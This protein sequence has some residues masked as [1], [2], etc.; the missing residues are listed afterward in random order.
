MKVIDVMP[1]DIDID[2]YDDYDERLGIAFCGPIELTD[3]AKIDWSD[4][5]NMPI[6]LNRGMYLTVH[7]ETGREAN[8]AKNF[9]ESLAGYCSESKWDE[10]FEHID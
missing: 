4:V 5:L 7:C 10:W 3:K 6:T 1:F 9:F 8:R 2:V